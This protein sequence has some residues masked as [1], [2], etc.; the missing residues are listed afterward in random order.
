MA[1]RMSNQE[2]SPEPSQTSG[3]C[4]W[5]SYVDDFAASTGKLAREEPAKAIGIAFIAGLILTVLPMGRVLGGLARVAVA[6]LRPALIVL[7]AVK[8]WEEIEKR[9]DK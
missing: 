8:V 2:K 6:L 4:D 5:K 7:G 3:C 1:K 9:A